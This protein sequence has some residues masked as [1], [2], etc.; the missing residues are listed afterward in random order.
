MLERVAAEISTATE[1]LALEETR[2]PV[3]RM[4]G[5]L[6]RMYASVIVTNARLL[7]SQVDPAQIDL[8]TGK[9]ASAAHSVVPWV[10]FRKHFSGKSA[11]P[12][13]SPTFGAA[14]LAKE[15][16]VFVVNASYLADFLDAW[17]ISDRTLGPLMQPASTYGQTPST[18]QA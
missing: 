16:S 17:E 12:A 6:L 1:A 15:K 5:G 13:E 14:A 4:N 7:L 8:A 2:L 18:N 10:R 11:M 3:S 9:T